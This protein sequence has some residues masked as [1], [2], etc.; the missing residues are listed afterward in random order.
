M[1]VDDENWETVNILTK[2]HMSNTKSI[3]T[4]GL[5]K[6][7]KRAPL[8]LRSD[9][10]GNNPNGGIGGK[11]YSENR[12]GSNPAA[13]TNNGNTQRNKR[14]KS[15]LSTYTKSVIQIYSDSEFLYD[16]E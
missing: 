3:N 4:P 2:S 5:K 12:K 11:R 16:I 14:G 7:P 1:S 10:N 8:A 13:T 9:R 6:Y 15:K